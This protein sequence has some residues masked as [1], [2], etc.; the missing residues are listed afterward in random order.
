MRGGDFVKAAVAQGR[1]PFLIVS[2]VIVCSQ[3][4]GEVRVLSPRLLP[5]GKPSVMVGR[6]RRCDAED[7]DAQVGGYLEAH[8]RAVAC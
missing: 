5:P 6:A 2:A 3:E 1:G 8:A 4:R 7:L